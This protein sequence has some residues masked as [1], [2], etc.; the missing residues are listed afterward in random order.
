MDTR[1]PG[2][3]A[4]LRS[5]AIGMVLVLATWFSAAAALPGLGAELGLTATDE[6]WAVVAVQIGFAV[7][8]A[9][10]ALTGVA[11]R[12]GPRQLALIGG[13][14]AAAANVAPVARPS[15]W[16]LLMSRMV[17]GGALA[18]VYPP[19]LKAAGAWARGDH[20]RVLGTMIAALTLGSASPH[21]VNGL[22][23]V[24][25]RALLCITS[26]TATVGAAMVW[27]RAGDGPATPPRSR[28]TV[29]DIAAVVRSRPL[30]LTC[31]GY[32]GHVWELYAGWAAIAPL[33]FA[34]WG[35]DRTASLG[36]FAV[37]AFGAAAAVG[38]G[39]LGDRAGRRRTAIAAMA[40]SGSLVA[41]LG[42]A[43]PWP[44]VA[45][46]IALAWGAA[47]IADGG[48]FP[49]LVRDHAHPTLVGSVLSLQLSLGFA[50]TSAATWLVPVV[51]D[52]AGWR[53]ALICLAPGPALGALALHR[54]D[55]VAHPG[56]GAPRLA[57]SY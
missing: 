22:G 56:H 47:V 51:A 7:T 49:A 53:W 40:V 17:V 37:V 24:S 52:A 9:G 10:T 36:A 54:L 2:R 11:D 27:F 20:G 55:A 15:L 57:G 4:S 50:A 44:V 35:D 41:L 43:T 45:S 30:R 25:W 29:D 18:L 13:L 38:G 31:L 46:T 39:R 19:L 48:Q 14:V 8:A 16:V 6:R 12:V 3:D 32:V 23:P 34:M 33:M 21:L 26:G 42:F 5:L 28:V 1:N